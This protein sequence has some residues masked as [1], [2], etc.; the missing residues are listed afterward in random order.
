MNGN[1]DVYFTLFSSDSTLKYTKDILN[2]LAAPENGIYHFRY[3]DTYV[4]TDAK[5]MFNNWNGCRM[6]VV[7]FRSSAT[8][9]E[10]QWFFVPIRWVEII[11][12]EYVANF[13]TITFRMK[14]YPKFSTDFENKCYQFV[15]INASAKDY[16]GTSREH[17]QLSVRRDLLPIVDT[18]YEH[19]DDNNWLKIV[20][21]LSLI[22]GYESIHFLR[23][24]PIYVGDRRCETQNE[25]TIL[26][27]GKY[28]YV[29]IDYYQNEYTPNINGKI[30]VDANPGAITVASGI[31]NEL[32]SRYDSVKLGF[33]AKKSMDN[34]ISEINIYTTGN[35][36]LNLETK[37]IIPVKIVKNKYSQL[38]RSTIMAAGAFLVG[39][40]GI[41]GSNVDLWLRVCISLVGAGI[42]SI[43]NFMGAKE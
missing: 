29:K 33:Q 9:N 32:E 2:V 30:N 4:Q 25:F 22:S 8:A 12:V 28:V 35:H 42:M 7:V 15:G 36:N 19:A 27:E 1:N 16:F 17:N 21:A 10:D 39:L 13:Y 40:P 43:S 38:F 14:K 18:N 23:C 24:S 26:E 3:E 5:A 34:S 20:K 6:A 37:I 31:G 41:L 11:E